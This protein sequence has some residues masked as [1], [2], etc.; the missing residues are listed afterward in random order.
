MNWSEIIPEMKSDLVKFVNRELSG[1]KLYTIAISKNL[2]PFVRP[3]VRNG[4]ERSRKAAREAL[5]RRN[6]L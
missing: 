1:E 6:L 2:G 4:V 3:I 5:R